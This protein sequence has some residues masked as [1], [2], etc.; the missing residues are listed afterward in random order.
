L[1]GTSGLPVPFI[2]GSFA[3]LALA[4]AGLITEQWVRTKLAAAAVQREDEAR[5]RAADA[6]RVAQEADHAA[7][8]AMS[9]FLARMSHEVQT[10]VNAILGFGQLAELEAVTPTQAEN[11][12]HIVKSARHLNTLIKEVL[13]IT[14]IEAGRLRLSLEPVCVDEVVREVVAIAAPLAA[15]RHVDLRVDGADAGA[16]F[17][18]AD[19]Y[20]LRQVLLNLVLNAVKYNHAR[21]AAHVSLSAGT[22]GHV[23]IAVTDTG[24]GIVPGKVHRLFTAFDRLDAEHTSIEGTGLGLALSNRLV[25]AMN[26]E[27]GVRT[28]LGRGSTFWVELPTADAQEE[29]ALA[30]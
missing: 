2:M 22:A 21:G 14:A 19:R 20:R 12:S 1:L 16:P 27:I 18:N 26:G 5:V 15:A 29:A 30:V 25:K 7:R 6:L 13:D 9:E 17:V 24:P 3:V 8:V 23:R 11:A 28:E 10:P 4:L